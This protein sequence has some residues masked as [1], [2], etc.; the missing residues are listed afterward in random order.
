MLNMKYFSVEKVFWS[1]KSYIISARRVNVKNNSFFSR[2]RLLLRQ[3]MLF[4]GSLAIEYCL[5]SRKRF[6]SRKSLRVRQSTNYIVIL[7]VGEE[8]ILNQAKTIL[9]VEKV[10][11]IIRIKFPVEKVF[12]TDKILILQLFRYLYQKN[13]FNPTEIIF[14]VK[15]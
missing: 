7:Q 8:N 3:T 15:K 12:R 10:F 1:A 5:W 11:P 14:Q 2:K 9:K 6:L 13:T 4:G